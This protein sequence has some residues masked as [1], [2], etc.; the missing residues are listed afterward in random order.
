M[1]IPCCWNN[2]EGLTKWAWA[3]NNKLLCDILKFTAHPLFLMRCIL[4]QTRIMVNGK[5]NLILPLVLSVTSLPIFWLVFISISHSPSLFPVP[6][7]L[8]WQQPPCTIFI[9]V[10]YRSR[11]VC[12]LPLTQAVT[13]LRLAVKP[14]QGNLTTAQ[15]ARNQCM[16]IKGNERINGALHDMCV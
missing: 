12:S 10:L 14:L 4:E 1:L 6:H 2:Y 15:P 7:Y 8:F 13:V 16:D 3:F 11:A 5:I 9:Y